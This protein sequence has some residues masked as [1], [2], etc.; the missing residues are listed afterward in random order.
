MG[1]ELWKYDPSACITPSNSFEIIGGIV[2]Q[3]SDAIV[4]VT[5]TQTGILY[6]LYLD[7]ETVARLRLGARTSLLPFLLFASITTSS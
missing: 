1:T 2:C 3:G 4:K 5:N 6:R 7:N